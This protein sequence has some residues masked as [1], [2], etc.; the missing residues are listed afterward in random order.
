MI[1]ISYKE[2]KVDLNDLNVS[3]TNFQ[4]IEAKCLLEDKIGQDEKNQ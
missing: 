4:Q 2:I 3:R 1:H